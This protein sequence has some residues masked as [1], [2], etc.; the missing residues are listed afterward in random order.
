[1]LY[2]ECLAVTV[3]FMFFQEQMALVVSI[4]FLGGRSVTDGSTSLCMI[5][6]NIKQ[7]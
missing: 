5:K 1:M 6:G 2:W 7:D 3:I 4:Q